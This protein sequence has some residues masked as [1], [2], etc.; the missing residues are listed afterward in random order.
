MKYSR[1]YIWGPNKFSN[2]YIAELVQALSGTKPVCINNGVELADLSLDSGSLMFCDCENKDPGYYCNQVM[3]SLGEEILQ[4]PSLALL[5]VGKTS[6]IA[7][8]LLCCC[9]KGVFY[10]TDT[11]DQ[12]NKGV[13]NLLEG[14]EWLAHT[15][16]LETLYLARTQGGRNDLHEEKSLTRREREILQLILSGSTNQN[17]GEELGISSNTVKAHVSNLYK[18]IG[19]TNRV[20]AI[21]WASKNL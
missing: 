18:K 11:L 5:N 20:Q 2:E 17:V 14:N 16:L 6:S 8:Q 10:T 4:V 7:E 12:V 21:M 9:I 1:L 19:V 3:R 13:R 15:L